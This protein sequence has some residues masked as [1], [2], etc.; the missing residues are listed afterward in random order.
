MQN[1]GNVNNY[2]L[3]IYDFETNEFK[4]SGKKINKKSIF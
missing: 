1:G 2:G 4:Y 3:A